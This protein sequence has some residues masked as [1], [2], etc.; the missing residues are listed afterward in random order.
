MAHKSLNETMIEALPVPSKGYKLHYF[1]GY[2]VDRYPVPVGFAVRVMAT[3]TKS[4]LL[5]YR[6]TKGEHRNTLGQYPAVRLERAVREAAKLRGLVE[7]GAEVVPAKIAAEEQ[8][9]PAAK[10]VTVNDVLDDWLKRHADLRSYQHH[11][12]AFRRHVRP[13]IGK[14]PIH[15]LNKAP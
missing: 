11:E 12:S 15:G 14:L 8:R 5:C 1:A 13:A 9:A 6:D 4:F 3:G 10:V 7:N 2:A